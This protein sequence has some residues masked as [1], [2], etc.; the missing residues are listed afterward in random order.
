[1][2]ADPPLLPG[3]VKLTIAKPFPRTELTPVGASGSVADVTAADA[4]ADDSTPLPT[5]FV[6]C[7]VNVYVGPF[8]QPG[9]V[10]GLAEHDAEPLGAPVTVHPVIAEPPL[11]AGR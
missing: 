1:M 7:A 2:T 9:A 8:V 4:A 11:L 5:A 6:A 3:A 10:Q